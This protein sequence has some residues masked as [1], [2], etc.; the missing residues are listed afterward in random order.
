MPMS[1]EDETPRSTA[2]DQTRL[3][4]EIDRVRAERE[5]L[6]AE[7]DDLRRLLG[8]SPTLRDA[9]RKTIN[10]TLLDDATSE[11]LTDV[12]MHSA[13]A[14]KIALFASLFRGREDVYAQRWSNETT[15]K[16][17]Y[18]PAVRRGAEARETLKSKDDRALLP[19]TSQIVEQHL[20][21]AIVAGVY[22][23]LADGTCRL[24]ACD[25]DGDGWALDALAYLSACAGSSVP[26]ALE[27]SRSGNGAHVWTFFSEPVRAVTAR[28]LAMQL[29]RAAMDERC[30]LDLASYDR[31]FP[32]QDHMPKGG[33]GN[34]IAL[35]LQP[36]ARACGNSE[37]LDPSTLAPWPDQWR[38]LAQINRIGG[39]AVD[40]LIRYLP[41]IDIGPDAGMRARRRTDESPPPANI[42][43]TLASELSV[44]RSGLP[45][46]LVSALK[47][48]AM[49]H[50]PAWHQRSKLRLSTYN[51]PRFVRCYREDLAHLHLPRGL[52]DRAR[53]LI[54]QA[55]SAVDLVDARAAHPGT[56]VAFGLD[57]SD[58]QQAALIVL[59]S[60]D[61]GV[62]V[63]PPGA[64]KTRIACALIAERG[65]PTLVVAHTRPLLDQWRTALSDALGLASRQIGQHG[66]GRKRRTHIV[67]LATLQSLARLDD[68][69]GFLDGYGMLV[70]DECHHIPAVSFE[71]VVKHAPARFVL[72]LTATPVRRD[73]MQDIITM[74][75]GPIRHSMSTADA[76]RDDGPAP[77]LVLR[78]RTTP[79][80]CDTDELDR[81]IQQHFAALVADNERTGLICDDIAAATADG[82]RSIVLSQWKR[83]CVAITEALTER[84]IEPILLHGDLGKRERARLLEE[85]ATT[86]S[87][88]DLVVVATAQLLGEGFD[89]P[90]LDTLFLPFPIAF[91]GRLVQYTGR[92]MR[93]H[94]DKSSV[95]V[96]DYADDAVPVLAAMGAKRATAFR[97]LGFMAGA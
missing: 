93:S 61:C 28:R 80:Q 58:G 24:V 15:G 55:G 89:C 68:L 72:G 51:V 10:E 14:R 22:P 74:Q 11:L 73:G 32:S 82:R 31:L 78:T 57:L 6:R 75:C 20:R 30:E 27:R 92:L 1:A 56:E 94:P 36:Q 50:N 88:E 66:G 21:G 67:D 8:L 26:A 60:H 9:H 96:Y 86:P 18:A 33:Y 40:E 19:M 17:G 87:D 81:P 71:Q 4:D 29:L 25:F 53:A 35:P 38:F 3:A 44:E 97:S 65:V 34:L 90:Q 79:F 48:S 41:P 54:E 59:A 39:S 37:F 47:H 83:H 5:A 7:R 16:S 69:A 91:K 52:Q 49:L 85:L 95:H 13:P 45:P 43:C 12:D 62:L 23:M 70:I 77:A 46:S 64:G 63:A 76:K 42:T 2:I 84:G